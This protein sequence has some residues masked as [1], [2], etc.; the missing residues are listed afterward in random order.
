VPLTVL[1]TGAAGFVGRNLCAALAPRTGLTLLRYDLQSP[2]HALDEA[3]ARADV[4]FHLAGVNRPDDVG[5][6]TRGNTDATVDVCRRLRQAGRRAKV[7]LS[8]SIHADG[9]T[10]YGVSKRGAEAAVHDYCRE[11]GAAGVVYRFKNLFG[12]WSRP[13]YNSVTATFCHRIARDLPIEISDPSTVVELTYI[14][15]VVAALTGEL[16]SLDGGFRQA[17]P[18]ASHAITLRD[19]AARLRGFRELRM[20]GV[21][22]DLSELFVQ[23]LFATYLSFLPTDAFAY[24][25]KVNSDARGA[26]AEFLKG[27]SFGQIFVSRTKPG[28]TRG[29]HYHQTKVEKFLVLEGKA[30]IRFRLIDSGEVFEYPVEGRECRVV[31]IPPGYTHSIENVGTGELITLFWASELFDPNRPDTSMLPVQLEVDAP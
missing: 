12:K 15:A 6:F 10:P 20:S 7:V 26:L 8:S 21:V 4:V 16:N 3:A 17:A 31:D 9:D 2:A 18:L 28:V 11:T 22:P 27:G 14:D 13:D 25:L 5:D 23:Q 29:H 1:V 24:P 19:L 30:V